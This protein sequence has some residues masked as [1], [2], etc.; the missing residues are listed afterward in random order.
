MS[1]EL[2]VQRGDRSAKGARN[3]I[4]IS[5]RGRKGLGAFPQVREAFLEEATSKQVLGGSGRRWQGTRPERAGPGVIQK[6]QGRRTGEGP[7]KASCV[8]WERGMGSILVTRVAWRAR[9]IKGCTQRF[10]EGRTNRETSQLTLGEI[11][12]GWGGIQR[13]GQEGGGRVTGAGGI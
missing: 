10:G 13:C 6:G 4:H 11:G 9:Y 1:P 5:G 7:S 12:V 2:T 8:L 3:E